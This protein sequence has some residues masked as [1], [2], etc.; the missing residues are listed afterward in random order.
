MAYIPIWHAS[1]C[2]ISLSRNIH[3]KIGGA[4]TSLKRLYVACRR[5][6]LAECGLGSLEERSRHPD[7]CNLLHQM[8]LR[9]SRIEV[10]WRRTL[11]R[12][13]VPSLSRFPDE[14]AAAPSQ[15]HVFC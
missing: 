15:G 14:S 7:V 8:C 5:L 10:E 3:Y 4:A 9:G 2:V 11:A 6:Q 13:G 1:S 12:G